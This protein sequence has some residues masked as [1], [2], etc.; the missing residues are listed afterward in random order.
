MT[1]I[2]L[3]NLYSLAYNYQSVVTKMLGARTPKLFKPT[4]I[5][6]GKWGVFVIFTQILGKKATLLKSSNTPFLT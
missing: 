2:W 3:Q 5:S 4:L 1:K 6:C